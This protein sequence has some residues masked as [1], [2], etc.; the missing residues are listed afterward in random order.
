MSAIEVTEAQLPAEAPQ[1]S[2]DASRTTATLPPETAMLVVPETS[3]VGN[4]APTAAA[5]ASCTR[6]RRPGAID[7]VNAVACHVAPD[8]DAYW[9]VQPLTSTAVDPRL[10]SSTKSFAKGAPELPPPGKTWL[11]TRSGEALRAA[12]GASTPPATRTMKR[13]RATTRDMPAP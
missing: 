9:I 3:G 13:T 6:Y 11:T 10:K 5:D 12:G 7:P 2:A 4:A 8:A 1:L